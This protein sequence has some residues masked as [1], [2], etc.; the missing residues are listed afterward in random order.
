MHDAGRRS[1][2]LLMYATPRSG[3]FRSH[4]NSGFS[5]PFL[6]T[7]RTSFGFGVGSASQTGRVAGPA[8]KG[9]IGRQRF[10]GLPL[11]RVL[12]F[13]SAADNRTV[14]NVAALVAA[15]R[16]TPN[17]AQ[18]E[19]FARWAE[20]G[21][22]LRDV[23]LER[24][25]A[26]YRETGK[27][28]N[29]RELQEVVYG[30]AAEHPGLDWIALTRNQHARGRAAAMR[31]AFQR[32]EA[33]KRGRDVGWPMPRRG[34]PT[35]IYVH[36]RDLKGQRSVRQAVGSSTRMDPVTATRSRTARSCRAGFDRKVLAGCCR[37]PWSARCQRTWNPTGRRAV[38]S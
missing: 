23:L 9:G 37:S 3:G 36:T 33:G 7:F 14:G 30:F 5:V 25:L 20:V 21:S 18:T 22:V 11:R 24:D 38:S 26:R 12:P 10:P 8:S 15:R 1:S 19:R 17:R 13:Q 16:S 35:T 32:L 27:R 2:W 28:L 6:R 4:L 31:A 34:R 29:W